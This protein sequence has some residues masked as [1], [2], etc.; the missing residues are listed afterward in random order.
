MGFGEQVTWFSQPIRDLIG[1][2]YKPFKHYRLHSWHA[3]LVQLS[4]QLYRGLLF[5][6]DQ[7]LHRVEIAE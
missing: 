5:R 7:R 1:F 2:G 6:P 4:A 3:F